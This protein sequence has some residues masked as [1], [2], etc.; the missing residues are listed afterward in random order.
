MAVVKWKRRRSLCQPLAAATTLLIMMVMVLLVRDAPFLPGF[1]P[2]LVDIMEYKECDVF[3]TEFFPPPAVIT[4]FPKAMIQGTILDPT[5]ECNVEAAIKHHPNLTVCLLIHSE[6][7]EQISDISE[8]LKAIPETHNGT[9]K[10]LPLNMDVIFRQTPLDDWWREDLQFT[11]SKWKTAHMSDASRLAFMW[12]YAGLYLDHDVMIVQPTF[13][14]GINFIGLKS[15]EE[16]GTSTIQF[17]QPKH[18]FLTKW[19]YMIPSS[20]NEDQKAS[21]GSKLATQILVPFCQGEVP[22]SVKDLSQI[23][24]KFCDFN[25]HILQPEVL[26]PIPRREWEKLFAN[27][28]PGKAVANLTGAAT[29][30]GSAAPNFAV[31]L[32]HDLSRFKYKTMTDIHSLSLYTHLA[33]M[34]CPLTFRRRMKEVPESLTP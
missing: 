24:G 34:N 28:T 26:Y 18:P 12:K 25:L 14:L 22:S 16:L 5:F 23:S 19:L 7:Q 15:M 32:W 27:A 6:D 13:E 33:R 9:L 29:A 30:A 31:H 2:E 4:S 10:V 3:F 11:L 1:R 8:D 21:I 20:Y 17:N